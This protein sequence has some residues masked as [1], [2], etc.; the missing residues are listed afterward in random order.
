M[1][2]YVKGIFL[3]SKKFEKPVLNMSLVMSFALSRFTT[4]PPK[5]TPKNNTRLVF[6]ENVT[7]TT[8]L[9]YTSSV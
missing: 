4:T 5:D 6:A 8:A 2:K 9:P 7:H 3:T 1:L